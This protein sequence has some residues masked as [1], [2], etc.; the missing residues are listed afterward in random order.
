MGH[1][2]T[3]QTVPELRS[4]WCRAGVT[5]NMNNTFP[6]AFFQFSIP[7]QRLTGV[8]TQLSTGLKLRLHTLRYL[9]H[10]QTWLLQW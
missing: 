4:Q 10:L 1:F 3:V 5:F 6:T 8:V 9:L 7:V 2:L